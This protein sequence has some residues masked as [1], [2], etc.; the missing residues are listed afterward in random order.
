MDCSTPSI[1]LMWACIYVYHLIWNTLS[2]CFTEPLTLHVTN[3]CT[4]HMYLCTVHVCTVKH[5]LY[6]CVVQMYFI[7]VLY[8][9]SKMLHRIIIYVYCISDQWLVPFLFIPPLPSHPY[10]LIEKMFLIICGRVTDYH[11]FFYCIQSQ[12]IILQHLSQDTTTQRDRATL[13]MPTMLILISTKMVAD[14]PHEVHKISACKQYLY[15]STPLSHWPCLDNLLGHIGVSPSW[16]AG[17]PP[18]CL[19]HNVTAFQ[20][21]TSRSPPMDHTTTFSGDIHHTG[22]ISSPL[23]L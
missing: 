2:Y 3:E 14:Q 5:V 12:T 20:K 8:L 1:C 21:R 6:T 11:F 15:S 16:S 18:H 17:S 13:A 9:A 23:T 22:K 10:T 7:Q 19:A 4:V